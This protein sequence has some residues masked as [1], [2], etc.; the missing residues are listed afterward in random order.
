MPSST[1]SRACSGEAARAKGLELIVACHPDVPEVLCGDPTRLAQV[2]TNLGSNAVKFTE[3][4]EVFIRATA[5]A[6]SPTAA[7]SSR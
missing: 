6:A 3:A 1:R 5:I 2:L 7:P 4:G